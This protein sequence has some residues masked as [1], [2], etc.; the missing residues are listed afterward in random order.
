MKCTHQ[1]TPSDI[2]NETTP[3]TC[4]RPFRKCPFPPQHQTCGSW[5]MFHLHIL[6]DNWTMPAKSRMSWK[7]LHCSPFRNMR[8]TFLIT[9]IMSYDIHNLQKPDKHLSV[10]LNFKRPSTYRLT[11]Q[12]QQDLNRSMRQACFLTMIKAFRC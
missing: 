8:G 7:G 12:K 5:L 3:Y 6:A 10:Y 1:T 11:H 9:C 2:S 4:F